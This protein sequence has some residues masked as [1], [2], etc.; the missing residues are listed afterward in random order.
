MMKIADV[1]EESDPDKKDKL[2]QII[3]DGDATVILSSE[4][5]QSL[6]ELIKLEFVSI[7]N[8]KLQLTEKGQQAKLI[9]VKG[10]MEKN[11]PLTEELK[12]SD[13]TQPS[14]TKGISNQAFLIILFFFFISLLAIAALMMI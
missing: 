5:T 12:L 1:L 3:E 8:E 7:E 10:A 6:N 2:L 13:F 9:G 11:P 4:Y 14:P